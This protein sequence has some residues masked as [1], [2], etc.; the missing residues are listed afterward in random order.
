MV[1]DDGCFKTP[2]RRSNEFL[3]ARK[4]AQGAML[5]RRPLRTVRNDEW[6]KKPLRARS[7]SSARMRHAVDDAGRRFPRGCQR[8]LRNAAPRKADPRSRSSAIFRVKN[9]CRNASVRQY[10]AIQRQ[11][12]SQHFLL[13]LTQGSGAWMVSS[14]SI[15]KPSSSAAAFMDRL[16]RRRSG[17]ISM[18]LTLTSWPTLTT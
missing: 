2:G 17:L 12:P 9:R 18:T 3:R 7:C 4:C 5:F 11:Q 14:T 15:S 6:Y 16:M 8:A 10:F 1:S 13:G